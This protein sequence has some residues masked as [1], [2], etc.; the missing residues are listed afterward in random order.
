M[1][2][3]IRGA[4]IVDSRQCYVIVSHRYRFIF[5][6]T[7]KTAGTSIELYLDGLCGPDD[8][9]TPIG[10]DP[11]NPR[12]WQGVFNPLPELKDS[13]G[14]GLRETLQQLRSRSRFYN[15]I[16]AY[17][18]RGRLPRGVFNDYF[19]FCVERNPW[20]KTVSHY[21]WVTR[22]KPL[23]LDSYLER[24]RLPVD[25][26]LYTAPG[27][28]ALLVDQ[29]LR[30][31][32]LDAELSRVFDRLGVPFGGRLDI[33]AKAQQRPSD[34]GYRAVLNERHRELIRRAFRWEIAHFGWEF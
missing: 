14:R 11:N 23:S 33:H 6:K 7:R 22:R 27:S 12:N 4:S 24:G 29:I 18:I 2:P 31:E 30:Y 9:V 13:R 34:W 17:R 1:R 26:E 20:D 16:E 25:H 3:V 21:R 10:S 8:A 32:D 28:G 5:I 15:H 19:K